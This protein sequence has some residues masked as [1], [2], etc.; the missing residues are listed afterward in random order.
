MVVALFVMTK[1]EQQGN[2][3]FEW[4]KNAVTFQTWFGE[5]MKRLRCKGKITFFCVELS[6][7]QAY[8]T[9]YPLHS[10]VSLQNKLL[11][12]L[13]SMSI[14]LN[15]SFISV[16]PMWHGK[17]IQLM[18]CNHMFLEYVYFSNKLIQD[19]LNLNSIKDF[20]EH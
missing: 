17:R 12:L 10:P 15:F 11:L 6:K 9:S 7:C 19:C 3:W 20:D 8:F 1:L 4:S 14:S 5:R 13:I 2:H 18:R 16:L